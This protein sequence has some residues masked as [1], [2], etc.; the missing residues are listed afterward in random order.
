MYDPDL[1][2]RAVELAYGLNLDHRKNES[3]ISVGTRQVAKLLGIKT[4]SSIVKWRQQILTNNDI[5][6]QLTLRG[7]KKKLNEKNYTL[8][9]TTKISKRTSYNSSCGRKS[10]IVSY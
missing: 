2:R 9:Q 7:S 8:G 1:K 3:T 4:Y 10:Q 5:K 6:Y